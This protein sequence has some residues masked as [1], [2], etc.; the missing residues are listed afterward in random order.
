MGNEYEFSGSI[1][2][3]KTQAESKTFMLAGKVDGIVKTP[4]GLF[5]MEY[6]TTSKLMDDPEYKLWEDTQV[7]IYVSYLR[8]LGYYALGKLP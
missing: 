2:N 1:V 7:G 3:P 8:D 4:S 6:K 5:L